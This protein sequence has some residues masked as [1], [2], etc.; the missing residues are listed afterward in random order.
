MEIQLLSIVTGTS[1]CNAR[2]PFCISKMTPDFLGLQ[3]HTVNWRNFHVA[4]KLAKSCNAQTVMITGKGEPVLFPDEI[5][6]YLSALQKYDFPLIELQT[7][8]I[9]LWELKEKYEPYLRE[10]YE[11]GLTTIALS[12]VHYDAEKNRSIYLPYKKSYIDLSGLIGHLHKIGFSV[13]L[14]CIM[15]KDY[16]DTPQELEKLIAFAKVNHVEQLTARPV[17]APAK[18]AHEDVMTWTHN[19]L[20][21]KENVH[22]VQTYLECVGHKIMQKSYG[23]LLYDVH[24][25]NVC[26]TNSLT[27]CPESEDIRQLIFFPDGHIRHDWQYEGAVVL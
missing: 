5:S 3:K 15:I 2:C 18:S 17:N 27:L 4:A 9:L 12:I 6:G 20:I 22:A 13:R 26:F 7:N 8:G 14:A 16:I 1:A 10:W 24:G 21:E 19:H 23:A 11:K 25:Q